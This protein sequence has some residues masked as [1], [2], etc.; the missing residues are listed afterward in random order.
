MRRPSSE[1]LVTFTNQPAG[2]NYAPLKVC[3]LTETP[4]Y[5]GRSFSFC[6]NGGPLQSTEAND[7]FDDPANYTCRVLG[8]FQVGSIVN[9]HEQIPAGSEVQWIDTDPGENLVDFN[10]ATGDATVLVTATATIVYYDNEPTP[11]SG[12][13]WIEVCKDAASRGHLTGRHR[14]V[15]LHR[16]G[17]RRCDVRAHSAGGP[18]LRADPG[19]SRCQRG[20]RARTR[21]I[22]TWSTSSRSRAT[23]C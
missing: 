15:R 2:G 20:R 9:V 11:P 23:A 7:A 12:T 21:R 4:A 10:T 5:L 8:T 13:G 1:T 22:S 6:V 3:K 19:R 18:V 17:R 14:A 16:H